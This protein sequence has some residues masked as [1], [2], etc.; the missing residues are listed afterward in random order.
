MA[1][2]RY[3]RSGIGHCI[4]IDGL[5]DLFGGPENFGAVAVPEKIELIRL[6][7]KVLYPW[8]PEDFIEARSAPLTDDDGVALRVILTSEATYDWEG[9]DSE[10]LPPYECRVKFRQKDKIVCVD[11]SIDCCMM[12]VVRDGREIAEKN[13][14]YG[15]PALSKIVS[16]YFPEIDEAEANNAPLPM[17]PSV[18]PRARARVAPAALMAGL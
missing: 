8:K 1:Q 14:R 6:K 15:I 10:C 7:G 11:L 9:G 3:V 5:I 12:R 17:R 13:I 16:R 18:T 4:R 2:F